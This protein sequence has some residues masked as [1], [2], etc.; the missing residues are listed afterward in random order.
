MSLTVWMQ[1]KKVDG[2]KIKK[3]VLYNFIDCY[4][5]YN[6]IYKCFGKKKRN[7]MFIGI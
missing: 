6:S 7:I 1:N 2:Y 4:Y 3:V 5:M